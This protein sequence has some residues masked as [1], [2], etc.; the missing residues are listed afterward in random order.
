MVE[1]LTEFHKIR[2][3]FPII[4][5]KWMI[6]ALRIE[7]HGLSILKAFIIYLLLIMMIFQHINFHPKP[8]QEQMRN[9]MLEYHHY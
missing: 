4:K 9:D 8:Q 7:F 5:N 1:S 3:N 2:P 6:K